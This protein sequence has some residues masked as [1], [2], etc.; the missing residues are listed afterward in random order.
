MCQLHFLKFDELVKS[1]NFSVF[2]IPA[3]A[4]IQGN[5]PLLDSRSP[6]G[7]EDKLR[8]SDGLGDFLRDHHDCLVKV[9]CCTV[10]LLFEPVSK[11]KV[12]FSYLGFQGLIL[13]HFR[14]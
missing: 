3:N 1:R 10:D 2:V 12:M 11:D 4:G 6:I 14:S 13:I 7:V 9:M 5:Q 8:G